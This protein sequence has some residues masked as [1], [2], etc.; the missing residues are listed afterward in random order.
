MLPLW[1]QAKDLA[2][3]A[4]GDR[5]RYVDYLRA[6]SNR[7]PK[8]EHGGM[9]D[10]SIESVNIVFWPFSV[11]QESRISGISVSGEGTVLAVL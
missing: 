2:A 3:Q 11:V 4:L 5:N 1:S 10:L 8:P 6:V 9:R 7:P